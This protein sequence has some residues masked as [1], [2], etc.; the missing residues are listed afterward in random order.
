VS[1]IKIKGQRGSWFANAGG[2][3]LPCVHVE[4]FQPNK[5][6]KPYYHDKGVKLGEKKWDDFIEGI[7]QKKRVILT[8]DNF[9]GE[10]KFER[11]KYVAIWAVDNLTVDEIGL[12]FD[13]IDRISEAK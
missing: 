7:K 4:W 10:G 3:F 9:L 8:K 2:E 6:G 5:A 11:T 1:A 12:R 13:F